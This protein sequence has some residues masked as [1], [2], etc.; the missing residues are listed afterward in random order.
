MVNLLN[1]VIE[2]LYL[3]KN[4]GVDGVKTGYLSVEK[5]SLASSMKKNDRR[6]IAVALVLKQKI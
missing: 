2:I 3:Y 1:K 6:V 4:V 5:Y